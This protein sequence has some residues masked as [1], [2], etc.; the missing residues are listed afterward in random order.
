METSLIKEKIEAALTGAVAEVRDYTG[1]GDH[2]EVRVICADFAGKSR[3]ERHQ[4]I[5][6]ALG[7]D[8]DGTTIHALALQ[9]LTPEQVAGD[10]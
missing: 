5:Y 7:K 3:V 6:R 9:A 1:S 2:F 8:V 10:A 4:M